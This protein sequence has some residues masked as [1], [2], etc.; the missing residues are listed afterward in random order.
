MNTRQ[1]YQHIKE[2]I[3]KQITAFQERYGSNYT[4]NAR[5]VVLRSD[6][7]K[8]D[9]AKTNS[10]DTNNNLSI[11]NI[12]NA[13]FIIP[14]IEHCQKGYYPKT[15]YCIQY[16][17]NERSN[18]N[19]T[20][21]KCKYI[22]NGEIILAMLILGYDYDYNDNDNEVVQFKCNCAGVFDSLAIPDTYESTVFN[23]KEMLFHEAI[24]KDS[25]SI[26]K[27]FLFV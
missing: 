12:I 19:S 16:A 17:V 25:F 11:N 13:L 18:D 21:D 1:L 8:T 20:I 5:G 9:I 24:D 7:T 23:Y 3:P 27:S 14:M 4:I 6:T 26:V 15:S 10:N 2:Q 22:T